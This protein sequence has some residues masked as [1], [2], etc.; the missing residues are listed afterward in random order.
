MTEKEKNL[1]TKTHTERKLVGGVVLKERLIN[2][3]VREVRGI[4][5]AITKVSYFKGNDPSKW[6][7]GVSTYERVSLGEVYEGIRLELKAYGSNV[8]KLFYISPKADPR[9]IRVKVEG[10]QDIRV[11]NGGELVLDT[12]FGEVKFTKPVAYQDVGG[13][14]KEVEVSYKVEKKGDMLAYGFELGKYDRTRE[15][16]ID[17]LLASTFLGGSDGDLG[18]SI[19]FDS[20]G[21]VYV[22]GVIYSS[23][24]PTTP[25]AYDRTYNGGWSDVFVSNYDVFVSKLNN[26]LSSLLAS[27]F[28]GGSDD[29]A[30]YSIALDS[31]GNVYVAGGT[32]SSNFPTTQ[33]VFD[34]THNGWHDVFVSKLTGDLSGGTPLTYTL[35][36]TK[37]GTGSGTV[38]SNPAGI[39]C[40]T[41]CSEQYPVGTNVTLTATASSGSVFAGWSGGGC[42]GTNPTCTVV[43]NSDITVTATFNTSGGGGSGGGEGGGKGGCFI[44]TAAYGSYLAPEVKVLRDFR[45]RY[46]MSIGLGRAFVSLYYQ[47]SPPIAEYISRHESLRFATRLLLT[48]VVYGIKYPYV[49]IGLIMIAGVLVIRRRLK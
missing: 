30:G 29:D 37:T 35:T 27:T 45:D 34:T 22:T 24:F 3:Q 44:A 32:K 41:D 43:M 6:Q 48:P 11:N 47:Y 28:L 15:L 33:G 16:V 40:G 31:S 36:V 9:S 21:N 19:A 10:A 7:S 8:E 49:V 25:G 38:T 18:N 14:R 12:P 20:S 39:N 13:K 46:L 26:S 23:D 1:K 4:D 17:P 5:R 2:A 42:S